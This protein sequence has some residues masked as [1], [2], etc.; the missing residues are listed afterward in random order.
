MFYYHVKVE[1]S[2][3]I[4]LC[5]QYPDDFVKPDILSDPNFVFENDPNFQA[6]QL[7]DGDLNTI[8][9]NSFIEC[10]HYVIGGWDNS[11][12]QFNEITLHNSLSLIMV[13][14]I[15][16]NYIFKKFYQKKYAKN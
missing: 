13:S 15:L 9:V 12:N 16:V 3:V 7:Y 4:N 11:P 14:V 5:G 8:Y 6:I 1:N 2:T 10:Q